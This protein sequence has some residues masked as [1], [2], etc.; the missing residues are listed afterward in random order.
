MWFIQHVLAHHGH[1]GGDYDPDTAFIGF[2]RHHP[3]T[4]WKPI[5]RLQTIFAYITF[6][7]FPNLHKG[8]VY[9]Y[10]MLDRKENR[11]RQYPLPELGSFHWL[12][13]EGI[14]YAC[15]ILIH[16]VY[17][18]WALPSFVSAFAVVFAF[19][20]AAGFCFWLNV[21]P[22]HDTWE[23]RARSS[24]GITPQDLVPSSTKFDWGVE[25]VVYSANFWD[26]ESLMARIWGF[27]FGGMN[28]QIE[29]HLFPT[30]SHMH[31]PEIA[32]IVRNTCREFGV[33]YTAHPSIFHA[34]ADYHRML[35]EL[36]QE[37][38]TTA[39]VSCSSSSSFE[40]KK[41]Q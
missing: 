31:Y 24:P 1:T 18:F 28:Y 3:G 8:L 33:P 37:P 36:S 11:H 15:S 26:P 10:Q 32:P 30:L 14:I 9:H 25:Q 4:K 7:L 27:F 34:V 20:S 16:Y 23:T 19:S 6:V 13:F 17:P 12:T 22:N 41:T 5:H 39:S 40:S 21:F 29:H 38:T 35:M 2:I